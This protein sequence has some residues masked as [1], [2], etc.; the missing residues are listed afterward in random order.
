MNSFLIFPGPDTSIKVV[1]VS[2]RPKGSRRWETFRHDRSSEPFRYEL[3]RE[4]LVALK[5][6]VASLVEHMKGGATNTVQDAARQ[7]KRRVQSLRHEA[8]SA[9]RSLGQGD[10]SLH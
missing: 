1:S 7:I 2:L 8:G 9:K 5:R 6:D 3:F 4:G 10:Q